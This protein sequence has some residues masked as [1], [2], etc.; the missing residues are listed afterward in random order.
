MIFF[1]DVLI[2]TWKRSDDEEVRESTL[3]RLLMLT[4]E[5]KKELQGFISIICPV[6]PPC[7]VFIRVFQQYL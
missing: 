1:V 2:A 4:S 3:Q 6:K 5:K 7:A